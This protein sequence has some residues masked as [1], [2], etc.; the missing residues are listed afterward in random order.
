MKEYDGPNRICSVSLCKNHLFFKVNGKPCDF[1]QSHWSLWHSNGSWQPPRGER[2][3]S[4]DVGKRQKK[5]KK[6]LL[7]HPWKKRF[8]LLLP[9]LKNKNSGS[10]RV[11]GINQN[12]PQCKE[13]FST[14]KKFRSLITSSSSSSTI[15]SFLKVHAVHWED[16]WYSSLN[17]RPT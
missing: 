8:C 6:D 14:Q 15:A 12:T 2:R 4:N 9:A 17:R 16:V 13:E 10:F 11:P 7:I 3:R 5:D 1:R